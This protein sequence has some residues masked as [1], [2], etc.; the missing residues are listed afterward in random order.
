M[1]KRYQ[2]FVS[3]TYGDLKDERKAAMDLIQEAGHIPAGMEHFPAEHGGA[4]DLIYRTIDR[5]DY[6][7]L[8]MAAKYG[9]I[10]PSSGVSYTELEYDYALAHGLHVIP[11]VFHDLSQRTVAQSEDDPVKKA[12]LL[13]FMR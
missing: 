12:K 6:Y 5:S 7:V 1:D 11:L 2:V 3:A 4:L 9:S 10:E 8:I 13:T